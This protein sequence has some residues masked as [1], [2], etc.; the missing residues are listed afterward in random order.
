MDKITLGKALEILDLN[1]KDG[2]KA[3]P[4]DVQTALL[5]SMDMQAFF[6]LERATYG[7][8]RIGQLPHEAPDK[9]VSLN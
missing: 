2:Q 6:M 7:Y 5:L 3:I 9:D 4:R 1:L 8:T